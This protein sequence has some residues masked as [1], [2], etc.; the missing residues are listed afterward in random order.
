MHLIKRN[1]STFFNMV[2]ARIKNQAGEF[3]AHWSLCIIYGLQ[4]KILDL[5]SLTSSHF[6]EH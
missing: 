3:L 5:K 4:I 1:L 6:Q 2:K